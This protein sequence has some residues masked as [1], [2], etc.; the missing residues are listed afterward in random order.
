MLQTTPFVSGG[1]VDVFADG[2]IVCDDTFCAGPDVYV[3]GDIARFPLWLAGGAPARIEHW[4][5]A[6]QQG[7]IAAKN[8]CGIPTPY[9]VRACVRRAA[10]RC[11]RVMLMG[12]CRMCRSSG[13]L[14][15]ARAFDSL[16]MVAGVCV[17]VCVCVCV[18]ACVCAR[19]RL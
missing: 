18:H 3:A 4:C 16:A 7:R 17:C 12:C 9:R 8:M 5:V 10:L 2:G 11:D 13:L 19:V 14:C 6:E 15:L 1:G